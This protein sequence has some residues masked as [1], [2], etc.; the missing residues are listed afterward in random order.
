VQATKGYDF[1]EI[2]LGD[3]RSST[4]RSCIFKNRRMRYP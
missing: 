4:S 1:D 2:K 3:L